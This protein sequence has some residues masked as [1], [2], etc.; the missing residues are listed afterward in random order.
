MILKKHSVKN[1]R[2]IKE[3]SFIPG[4]RLT[5][6]CGKN[7]QGKTNLLESIWLLSGAKS[8]RGG[9]DA[10]LVLRGNAVAEIEAVAASKEKDDF[11]RIA[12]GGDLAQKHGRY[13]KLNGVDFGRAANLAGHF[14]AVVFA[15]NHLSL[16]KGSPDERR[17]FVDAALC[18]LYPG[19]LALYRRY[20][21]AL[22][23]KNALLKDARRFPE[24][25]QLLD[26]FDVELG[27]SGFEIITY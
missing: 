13:A 2:N 23:Q 19:Y 27:S 3:A 11:F 6:I 9:K 25:Q 12:I 4:K 26:S 24:V 5:V 8:F 20:S 22:A 18:Q 7:G 15:P 17:R 16:I 1:Y 10:D 21:R 14:Y